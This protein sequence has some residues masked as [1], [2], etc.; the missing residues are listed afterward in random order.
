MTRHSENSGSRTW[1]KLTG[2]DIRHNWREGKG[3]VTEVLGY[4][5]KEFGLCLKG[6]MEQ[7]CLR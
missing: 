3:K 2:S 6:N 5:D 1:G 7:K 4:Q